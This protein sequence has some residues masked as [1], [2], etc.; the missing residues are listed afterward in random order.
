MPRI[1]ISGFQHE[2][3]S[4]S[5]TLAELADFE[6]TDSWPGLLTGAEVIAGTRGTNRPVAGIV[7]AAEAD[8]SVELVQ[9]LW[10]S[11]EPC[12]PVTDQRSTPSQAG[13]RKGWRRRGGSMGYS[14]TCMER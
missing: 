14:S 7:L 12:G 3:N 2:T 11:A 8:P 9:I 6:L 10:A 1:A 13:M 5:N 4:F